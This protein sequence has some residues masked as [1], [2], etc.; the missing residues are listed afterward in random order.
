MLA[1][2][3]DAS[4]RIGRGGKGHLIVGR[5]APGYIV[6]C[7]WGVILRYS[8]LGLA[9]RLVRG[10]AVSVF[11]TLPHRISRRGTK[12]H[13]W[14]LNRPDPRG[15]CRCKESPVFCSFNSSTHFTLSLFS[16]YWDWFLFFLSFRKLSLFCG[17]ALLPF[18]S[19]RSCCAQL[20]YDYNISPSFF[21]LK[22]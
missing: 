16:G 3:P 10:L 7:A 2:R 17:A 5:S 8:V 9:T 14:L 1:Q 4:D 13:H 6:L 22:D 18:F 21:I 11:E 15:E 19:L 20:Y 12:L